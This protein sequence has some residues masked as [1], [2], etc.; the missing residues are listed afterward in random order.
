MPFLPRLPKRR[1]VRDRIADGLFVVLYLASWCAFLAGTLAGSIFIGLKGLLGGFVAGWLLGMWMRRS[2]GI[3][4]RDL[5]HGYFVH[6][7]ERGNGQPPGRLESFLEIV[8]GRRLNLSQCRR[9]AGIQAE[10]KRRLASSDSPEERVEILAERD[11]KLL[12]SPYVE[13]EL[14]DHDGDVESTAESAKTS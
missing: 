11:R 7:F 6:M 2:L 4:D 12:K 13:I 3:R 10:A 14:S 5:T 1:S 9:I 8:R